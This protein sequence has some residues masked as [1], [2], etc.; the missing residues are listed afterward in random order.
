[1]LSLRGLC[2][3]ERIDTVALGPWPGSGGAAG[4]AERLGGVV[5]TVHCRGGRGPSV[6]GQVD[7]WGLGKR[8]SSHQVG[9]PRCQVGACCLS[10][11]RAKGPPSLC[12]WTVE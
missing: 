8:T 1:M 5:Q 4:E 11:Q 6:G 7:A 2:S 9:S 3:H 10:K 12:W